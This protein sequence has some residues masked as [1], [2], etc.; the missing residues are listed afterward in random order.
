M[1]VR[2]EIRRGK[3]HLIID[4]RFRKPDGTLGRYRRDS[5]AVTKAAA[6]EEERRLKDQ[7]ARTGSPFE[8]PAV[9]PAPKKD[10]LTFRQ[11]VEQ[12]RASFM[13]TDLKASSRRGYGLVLDGM[14]LPKF[15]DLP[16]TA[17]DGVAASQL[18]L[19]LAQ[20]ERQSASTGPSKA[21]DASKKAKGTGKKDAQALKPKK[22]ARSTRNN[23]Q[24]ILRSLFRFAVE[25]GLLPSMP[26]GLPRLKKIGQTVLEIPSDEQVET[27]LK[28]AAPEHRLSFLLMADGGL[29]PNE[30]R[31]LR[32]RDV[33]L[34]REGDDF[35][36]GF[37]SVRE[38]VSF[39]HIDT[40]KTGQREI[41]LTPRLAKL[42]GQV[43]QR[44]RDG[45][46]A[47]NKRRKPWGQYGLAQAFE[48]VRDRADLAGWSIY[49]L[50]H[51]AITS[52]LRR[53]VPVHVVQKMAGHA[54]LS[55]TQRYVHCLKSDLEDA[56]R[57]LSTT[58][59][60][61][62]TAPGGDGNGPGGTA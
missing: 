47:L 8:A 37:L 62:E 30:V 12:F 23:V 43:E 61:W 26:T 13:V 27:I 33:Q 25:K 50:R 11:V 59:N 51:Y 14:L 60:R 19:E 57:R 44:P 46:V 18:D 34:K 24:I 1:A 55:T 54:N 31:A 4:F 21:K 52:W 5:E 17:V 56:A 35:V 9:E 28:L 53:G 15:A 16:I 22:L 29:R 41:P 3:R 48:R 45:H 32:W 38:G 10:V 6:R 49:A 40:P 2:E 58:G 7:I 36:G 39:G 42:L 20:R